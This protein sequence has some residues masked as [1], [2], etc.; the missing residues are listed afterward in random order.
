MGSRRLTITRAVQYG[1]QYFMFY[2]VPMMVGI[3]PTLMVVVSGYT[4]HSVPELTW[5]VNRP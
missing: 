1:G 3:V 5:C 4:D 2:S